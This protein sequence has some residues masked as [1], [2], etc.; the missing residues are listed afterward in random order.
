MPLAIT[1]REAHIEITDDTC[2]R[3]RPMS[4]RFLRFPDLKAEKGIPWCRMHIDRLEKQGKFPTR[5]RLGEATV[6]WPEEEIDAFLAEK[7]AQRGRKAA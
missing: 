3:W 6:A 4:R 7:T 2:N 5:V 1:S